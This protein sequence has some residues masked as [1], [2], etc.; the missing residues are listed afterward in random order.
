MMKNLVF[1]E[2]CRNDVSYSITSLPMIGSLAGERYPYI[3]KEA[4]C[5]D[6][7]SLVYAPEINDFNLKALCDE[8]RTE[9]DIISLEHI[10]EIPGKY[11]IEKQSLSLLL[12]WEETTFPRYCEGDMPTKQYSEIL[13]KIYNDPKYYFEILKAGKKNLKSKSVYRRSKKAVNKL[14]KH[15][16]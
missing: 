11:A 4:R 3:G 13:D 12:G 6:C 15:S 8:F 14:L 10:L 9:N 1:C 2:N 5:C 16:L 7:G